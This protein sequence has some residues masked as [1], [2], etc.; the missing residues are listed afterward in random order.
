MAVCDI[1]KGRSK[2]CKSHLGG[3]SK[4]YL[5]NYLADPFTLLDGEATAMNVLLTESFVYD[6]VGDGQVLTE[7]MV[8]DRSAGTR[9]NTQTTTA[10]V[11]G[12][13]FATSNEMKLLVAGTPQGIVQSND[14][15]YHLVGITHG[16]DFSASLTTGTTQAELNGYTLTGV[17]IEKDYSPILDSATVTAFLAT[18]AVNV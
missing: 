11:Q 7:E 5:F 9:V 6:L 15:N 4:L 1:T 8:G 16:I 14:G 3:A 13:D 18:V 10:I 2:P 17:S 12:I